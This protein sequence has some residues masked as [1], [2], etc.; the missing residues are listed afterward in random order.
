MVKKLYIL[1][2]KKSFLILLFLDLNAEINGIEFL[3]I[4]IR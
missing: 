2:E 1:K 3:V 4:K